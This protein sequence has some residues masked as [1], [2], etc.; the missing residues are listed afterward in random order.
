V[1]DDALR[2]NGLARLPQEAAGEGGLR[3]AGSTSR[4]PPQLFSLPHCLERFQG[5][6]KKSRVIN[7]TLDVE[8][9][10][11]TIVATAVE[12]R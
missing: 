1:R 3:R 12:L 8:M 4:R 9:V 7:S 2:R 10:L 6:G 11:T 5:A